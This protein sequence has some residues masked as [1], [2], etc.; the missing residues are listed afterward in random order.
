MV[1]NE[2]RLCLFDGARCQIVLVI[3]VKIGIFTVQKIQS[4][5]IAENTKCKNSSILLYEANHLMDLNN[6]AMK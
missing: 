1:V 3:D 6:T 2:Q 4:A 5:F